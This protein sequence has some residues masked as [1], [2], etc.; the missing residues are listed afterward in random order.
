M[1]QSVTRSKRDTNHTFHL[2]LSFVTCGL[3]APVWATVWAINMMVDK[4]A[5][6]EH[7]SQPFYHPAPMAPPAPDYQVLPD[8]HVVSNFEDPAPYNWAD[9]E[10]EV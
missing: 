1:Y 2:I 9:E 6:T 7:Y 8:G 3:W 5:V 10:G 4:K